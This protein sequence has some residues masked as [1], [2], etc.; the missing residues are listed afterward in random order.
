MFADANATPGKRFSHLQGYNTTMQ[1]KK[2][3]PAG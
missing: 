3:M 2:Q 1:Q